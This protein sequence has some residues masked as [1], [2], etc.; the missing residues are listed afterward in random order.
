MFGIDP[1]IE[2][3]YIIN[4]ILINNI[5]HW[6]WLV[7]VAYKIVYVKYHIYFSWWELTGYRAH[8]ETLV[9]QL[10]SEFQPVVSGHEESM[11]V[12]GQTRARVATPSTLIL[13][14]PRLKYLYYIRTTSAWHKIVVLLC[15]FLQYSIT[16][17][18]NYTVVL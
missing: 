11:K 15:G 2:Y 17:F 1:W 6:Y 16:H 13:V 8:S 4:K 3:I 5:L 14:W 9:M 10:P 12:G 7:D 18:P